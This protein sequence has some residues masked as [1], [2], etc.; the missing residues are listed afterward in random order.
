MHDI[1]GLDAEQLLDAYCQAQM[2]MCFRA[3]QE[4]ESGGYVHI[5]ADFGRFYDSRVR[6]LI[7]RV[8]NDSNYANGICLGFK[9]TPKQWLSAIPERIRTIRREFWGSTRYFWHSLGNDE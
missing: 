3:A 4:F 9:E 8:R 1:L 2:L 5:F 7:E 6:P